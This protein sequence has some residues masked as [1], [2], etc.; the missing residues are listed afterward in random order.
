MSKTATKT[1]APPVDHV[2][3]YLEHLAKERDV[4]AHT[5]KAY[6][7]DLGEFVAFLGLYYG[8]KPWTWEGI[9]RL[10]MRAFLAQ[11]AKRGLSKRSMSRVLSA[12]SRVRTPSR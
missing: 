6:R 8:E 11:L 5:V 12:R 7:R 2:R 3:E 10:A 4:S 9:D 1:P